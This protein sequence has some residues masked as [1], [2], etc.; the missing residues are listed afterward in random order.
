MG[1]FV[2]IR[3]FELVSLLLVALL[4]FVV[5]G[6]D[7]PD[8]LVQVLNFR[9]LQVLEIVTYVIIGLLFAHRVGWN[10]YCSVF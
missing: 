5:T 8:L 1:Q 6:I 2:G 10:F 7:V 3:H 9:L 4:G